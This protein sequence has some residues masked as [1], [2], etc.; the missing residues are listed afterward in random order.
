M[1]IALLEPLRVPEELIHELAT[2]LKEAGHEFVYYDEKTTDADELARRSADVDIVMIANNPYPKEAFATADKLK[3]INVAFTGVDHVDLAE[4]KERSIDVCNAAGYSNTAVAELT[5]GLTLDLFRQ[6]SVSHQEMRTET[7]E[8]PFQGREISGKT[9]GI[10]GAGEIGSQVARLFTA[11]GAKVLAYNR[12]EN[13]ELKKIGVEYQSLE[14]VLKTSDIVTIHLP[15]NEETI[16]FIDSEE[17]ALMKESAVLINCARGP[18]VNTQ[19]LAEALNSGQIA[20]AG[21]DVFDTE[22]P[23]PSDNPLIKAKNIVL[24]PHIAYLTD[25]AMIARTHI[26]FD[27]TVAYLKGE[28]QNLV[29]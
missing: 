14:E 23:L 24:T 7:F 6:I 5:I 4:A 28:P 17:L 26:A 3:L 13:E 15:Q 1:K 29:Q 9:V 25:E 19:A 27:N 16:D 12:S 21:V 22:P 18:I 10:I 20:G 8:V 2:P 11:F